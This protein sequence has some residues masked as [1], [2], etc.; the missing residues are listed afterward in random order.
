MPS[1]HTLPPPPLGLHYEYVFSDTRTTLLLHEQIMNTVTPQP[2]AALTGQQYAIVHSVTN[3]FFFQCNCN[4][5]CVILIQ[6]T[7]FADDI[8]L[9]T[10]VLQF[11]FLG[12]TGFRF[13]VA[14]FPCQECQAA[15][16]YVLVWDIVKHLMRTGFTVSTHTN[17]YFHDSIHNAP[18]IYIKSARKLNIWSRC[19]WQTLNN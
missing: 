14:H 18:N 13:P 9:A 4:T 3:T 5:V 17:L 10:H 8:K 11:F 1:P 12:D 19:C 16:I 7:D 15:E 2:K 6:C